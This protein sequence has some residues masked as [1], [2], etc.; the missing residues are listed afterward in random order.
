M[1]SKLSIDRHRLREERRR[2]G[3]VQRADED[4]RSRPP[5]S[6]RRNTE[7]AASLRSMPRRVLRAGAAVQA[8]SART[9]NRLPVKC[10]PMRRRHVGH[11]KDFV[12]SRGRDHLGRGPAIVLD[13]V[14]RRSTRWLVRP[15]DDWIAAVSPERA[16]SASI[17]GRVREQRVEVGLVS[18]VDPALRDAECEGGREGPGRLTA[19]RQDPGATLL[20]GLNQAGTWR[21]A[22]ASRTAWPSRL[23]SDLPSGQ[24]RRRRGRPRRAEGCSRRRPRSGRPPRRP[25]ASRKRSLGMASI[26]G[27]RRVAGTGARCGR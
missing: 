2:I 9:S 11:R 27:A 22:M 16:T 5:G 10:P 17:G 25:R 18:A 24:A 15:H 21:W 4:R 13:R 14:D 19:C 1:N 26:G 23:T 8:G 7:S 6:S 20:S 3:R 12:G